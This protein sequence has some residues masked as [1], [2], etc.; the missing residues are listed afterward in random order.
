MQKSKGVLNKSYN[1]AG[2]NYDGSNKLMGR[3]LLRYLVIIL[4]LHNL[5]INMGWSK[6]FGPT[7]DLINQ[8]STTPSHYL[9]SKVVVYQLR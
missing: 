3:A 7:V 8:S 1:I 4:S 6:A 5:G 2:I 9:R